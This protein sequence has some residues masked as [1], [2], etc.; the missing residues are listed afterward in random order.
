MDVP[1]KCLVDVLL[2]GPHMARYTSFRSERGYRSPFVMSE[3]EYR[4][5]GVC[6]EHKHCNSRSTLRYSTSAAP[7][8]VS[9]SFCQV[10]K[11][12]REQ[13]EKVEIA[14]A[15]EDYMSG[16]QQL[17]V[18]SSAQQPTQQLLQEVPV[19]LACPCFFP[20]KL[21]NCFFSPD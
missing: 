18:R 1:G 14:V 13:Q 9:T 5:D 21:I 6:A 19:L 16:H 2:A 20:D 12:C 3:T 15:V 8:S 4:D 7:L 10:L 11:V 17:E